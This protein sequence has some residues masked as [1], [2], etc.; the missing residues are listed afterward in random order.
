M[1]KIASILPV[2]FA[3]LVTQGCS[4]FSVDDYLPDKKVEYEKS[5]EVGNDLEIPPDLTNVR[6]G[7]ELYVPGAN[8]SGSTTYSEF[9]GEKKIAGQGRALSVN[10]MPK[11]DSITLK[12]EGD[13]RWLVVKGNPQMVWPNI[14]NFW[15]ENGILLIEQD[16]TVGVMKT[17]WLENRAD[18]GDDFITNQLKKFVGGLYSTS[19]RDQYRVRLEEGMDNGTTEVFLTHFG[20]QQV[21]QGSSGSGDPDTFIW[22]PRDRDITLEAEMLRRMMVFLGVEDQR[23][24]GLVAKQG[25]K[26]AQRSTLVRNTRE[27]KLV[28]DES[29][30]KT[31]RLTGLALDRVGFAV[32]DRDRTSGVY[33]VRYNDPM[34]DVQTEEGWLSNLKFWGND[35]VA[36]D[37]KY[38]IAVQGISGKTE[39][40]VL[41]EAGT[42]LVNETAGRILTLI[43][44]QLK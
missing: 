4:S 21:G 6:A 35:K 18:I 9:L 43:H 30:A 31:W 15:R 13:E 12:R 7:S 20:M 22:A 34:A 10:V 41:D 16:P 27:S 3:L 42:K 40:I 11:P 26:K 19:T 5:Q 44:E 25:Q 1:K 39:V 32:E 38:Q 8:G 2:A 28:V 23:A 24:E 14:V 17:G 29:F 33:Y 36:E 37:Q